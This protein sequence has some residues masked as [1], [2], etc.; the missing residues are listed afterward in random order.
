MTAIS[1]TTSTSPTLFLDV[2]NQKYAYRRFGTQ[3]ASAPPLLCLQH[4]TGTLD[5]WDP[6]VTDPLALTREVILF[7]NAGV[8]R[9][10]GIVP[11]TVAGMAKHTFAFLDALGIDRCDVL[12]FS[13]GGM[14]AQ[15]M[16]LDRPSIFR[17]MILVGTAP[18]GGEDLM[19]LDKPTLAPYLSDPNL[20][21]YSVLQKIFFTP[22]DASQSAGAEFT[23]RLMLR[24]DDRDA[25]SGP[26]VARAQ[27]ASFREW[28][29]FSGVRFMDLQRIN[30]P[31]LVV[32]GVHDEM[33][34]MRNS[35]WL[36]EHLGNSV[37]LV[38]PDAGHGSL[39]Q[40]HD[41]FQDHASRFLAS[42]S[43]FAP[44]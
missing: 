32:N 43:P 25:P 5:N 3:Q 24:T 39:F 38:Y 26:E 42:D 15:Q 30:Q 44:Y 9:S 22:T 7:D 37:L 4:F 10:T 13:L 23:G 8:G 17:R 12:G 29:Q 20:K 41:S 36:T 33:I 2:P 31:T 35:Y 16:A 27:M 19:H 11:E 6:A 34:P 28:E 1:T 18:R 14:V 21:G 40:W